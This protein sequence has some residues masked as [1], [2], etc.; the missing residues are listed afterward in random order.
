MIFH[1]SFW[2]YTKSV[3]KIFLYFA[4]AFY[5]EVFIV[6]FAVCG[7]LS[8][9]TTTGNTILPQI[10]LFA[11]IELG[12]LLFVLVFMPKIFYKISEL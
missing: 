3:I 9:S 6:M 4:M 2:N 1:K 7:G 10:E 8:I 12:V 11:V 5:V